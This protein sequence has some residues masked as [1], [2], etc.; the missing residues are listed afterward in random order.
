M[1]PLRISIIQDNDEYSTYKNLWEIFEPDKDYSGMTEE[2]CV[3]YALK[4]KMFPSEVKVSSE[5]YSKNAE[6]TADYELNTLTLINAKAKPEFTWSLLKADYAKKLLDLLGFTYNYK[7]GDNGSIKP[8]DADKFKVK[9]WD[10]NGEREIV[11]YL[12]Q[13]IEGTLVEYDDTLY[14][15]EFRIAFPER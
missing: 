10:F 2:E 15:E 8:V 9:Y 6:R 7:T 4:N 3:N 5:V 1:I 11:A 13:T 12:G 14:W